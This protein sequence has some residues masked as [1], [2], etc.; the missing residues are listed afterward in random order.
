VKKLH[1]EK[2][3]EEDYPNVNHRGASMR[4]LFFHIRS[5]KANASR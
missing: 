1:T 3:R 4:A 5:K 2:K